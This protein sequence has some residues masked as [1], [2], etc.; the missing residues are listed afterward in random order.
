MSAVTAQPVAIRDTDPDKLLST[1]E[2]ASILCLE[3]QTL[4]KWRAITGSP[5]PFVRL[6]RAVRYRAGDVVRFLDA[7][8]VEAA[9]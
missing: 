7:G 9:H 5:L 1:R 8:R 6:G 4:A 3:E 2:V